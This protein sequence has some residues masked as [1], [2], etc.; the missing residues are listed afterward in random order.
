M[1]CLTI[2]ALKTHSFPGIVVDDV[3]CCCF[4]RR[5]ERKKENCAEKERS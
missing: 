5:K 4:K 3:A 1:R 2:I